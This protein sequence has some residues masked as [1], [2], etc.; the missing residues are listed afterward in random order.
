MLVRFFSVYAEDC[1]TLIGSVK[2]DPFRKELK[3]TA[4]DQVGRRIKDVGSRHEAENLV[5]DTHSFATEITDH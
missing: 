4:L 1:E 5:R 3:W 2:H